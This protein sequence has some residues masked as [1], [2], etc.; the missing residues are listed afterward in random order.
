MNSKTIS[1]ITLSLAISLSIS[2]SISCGS[3]PSSSQAASEQGGG[4]QG[5]QPGSAGAQTVEVASVKSQKL[6]LTVRLPGELL[7]YEVVDVYPKVTGFVDAIVV[8][9]GSV[10]K[11]GQFMVR[12]VAP[13]IAA[14]RAEAES[15]L[16]A[17]DAQRIEAEAK[18]GSD[19]GTYQRLKAASATAGVVAG[20]DLEVAQ[21]AADADRARLQAARQAAEAAKA[22]SKSITEIEQYLQIR[23]PFDGRVTQRNFHPGALVG[24]GGSVPIVRVEKVSRLRLV[25]PV[26]ENYVGSTVHGAKVDFTVPT[27]PGEKFTGTIARIADSLDVK[28]RTMPVEL[29]VMNG[30]G[31][32]APGMY[33]EVDWPVHRATATLFVPTTAIAR[34]N[35]STFVVRVR[36]GSVEWVKVQTGEIEGKLVEVF[37]ELREGDQVALRGT[38]ELRPGT[39]VT[40][41]LASPDAQG[42]KK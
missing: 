2:L 32:L 15:K 16:Q 17:A 10:V 22:A 40:A 5:A 33:P 25:L 3:Q 23:A 28:T 14:Q 36:D 34:T 41:K 42:T 35:E 30:S 11:A 31:R 18:L 8:D 12:L 19:E 13:E 39:K 7:P 37:G 1:I 9:R 27:F 6:S 24:P 20:N 29:D 4:R 21:K 38:D 26:P